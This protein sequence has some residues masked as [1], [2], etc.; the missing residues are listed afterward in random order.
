[1]NYIDTYPE[2]GRQYNPLSIER[3]IMRVRQVRNWLLS[4]WLSILGFSLLIA[5]ACSAYFYF[6]NPTYSAQISFVLDEQAS[7]TARTD[8]SDLPAGLGFRQRTDPSGSM[9]STLNNVVEL[10]RSRLLIEKTLKSNV[11]INGKMLSLADFFLDSLDY[12]SQW[13]TNRAYAHLDFTQDTVDAAQTLYVNALMT[14]MYDLLS[15]KIITIEKKGKGTSIIEVTCTS[16]NESF[17]KYFIETLISNTEKYYTETKTQRAKIN[18][19]F[20]SKRTD[21][22]RKAYNTALLGKAVFTDAN[23]N[24]GREVAVVSGEKQQT[25]LVILRTS[26]IEL[27]RSLESAKTSLSRD[28]PLF[29]YLDVPVFPLKKN[30]SP[31]LLYFCVFFIA[32]VFLTSLVMLFNKWLE[33]ISV[34]E[35]PPLI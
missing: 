17:S 27:S 24:P 20:V 12:R 34:Q 14:R 33:V 23:V 1:M 10:I 15:K 21:S 31:M 13:T 11:D 4:R 26:Y 6:K 25:D 3:L 30:S 5:L 35:E 22:V 18:L 32:S 9:F 16:E 29:Q 28:I 7:E 2:S 19:D 8:F